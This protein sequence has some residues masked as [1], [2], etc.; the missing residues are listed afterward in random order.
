MRIAIDLQACQD[1][2]RFRG[3]GRYSKSLAKEMV[4]QSQS[5]GHEILILLNDSFPE[6]IAALSDEFLSLSD[7]VRIVVF[8]GIR[9]VCEL[10]ADNEWRLRAAELLRELFIAQLEPDALHIASVFEGTADDAFASVGLIADIPTALTLYDLIPMVLSEIYLTKEPIISYYARKI[11]SV[12]RANLL[13]AISEH[14]RIDAIN[15]LGFDAKHAVNIS[16]SIDGNFAPRTLSTDESHDLM[17]RYGIERPFILYVPGGFD[18]RKNFVRL[19]EAYARLPSHIR[20]THQLVIG[21]EI[22]PRE[23]R[24]LR[25]QIRQKGLAPDEVVMTGYIA[26]DDL[27]SLYSICQLHV[28]PSLYEGFGLPALE[29]LTCG[30]PAIASNTSSLPE[31]IDIP[32]ALFDPTSP[33]DIADKMLHALTDEPFRAMLRIHGAEQASRFSWE[34]S[35]ARALDAIETTFQHKRGNGSAKRSPVEMVDA[36]LHALSIT[37]PSV[38]PT[39]ED[40]TALRLSA[41]K[42]AAELKH[43]GK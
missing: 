38:E 13:L 26:E 43:F 6:S 32:E 30:A 20:E 5:R 10:E 7:T 12:K 27:I 39:Q 3:I 4:R 23:R 14:S 40:L 33:Q 16:T 37:K 11:E 25:L 17:S 24:K 19:F 8:P 18:P 42:G 22:S 35:A 15:L 28:F 34:K 41:E 36:V 9:N 31:V 29:S 2:S 21:S 1:Y